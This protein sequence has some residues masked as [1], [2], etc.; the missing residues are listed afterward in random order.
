MSTQSYK[1]YFPE[2]IKGIQD[3]LETLNNYEFRDFRHEII[4]HY[5]I[6]EDYRD[7]VNVS[8]LDYNYVEFMNDMN[9]VFSGNNKELM[10]LY[11]E[12]RA[13]LELKLKS[14]NAI[15]Q[16]QS[17]ITWEMYYRQGDKFLKEC[18]KRYLS[19]I[20]RLAQRWALVNPNVT[21]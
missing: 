16:D 6:G 19:N 10:D 5:G 20:S 14:K 9:S 15:I 17:E 21:I 3:V 1:E 2:A 13:K 7:T 11:Y 4:I 18:L 12:D 8:I